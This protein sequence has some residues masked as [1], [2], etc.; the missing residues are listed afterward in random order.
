MK[1]SILLLTAVTAVVLFATP[2]FAQSTYSW[3]ISCTKSGVSGGVTWFWM[4]NGFVINGNPALG[5]GSVGCPVDQ[6]GTGIPIPQTVV[7]QTDPTT[8]L[9]VNGIQVNLS[10]SNG[11]GFCFANS[12]ILK[13]FSPSDPKFTITD[14]ISGPAH[15]D[16]FG[17]K[18][19][20]AQGSLK[21][22]IQNN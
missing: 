2:G 21:F 7:S 16:L 13:S 12:T 10:V 19:T 15:Y 20:C 6:V 8:A 3:A 17:Q 4:N 18:V 14:T 5:G 11:I 1:R 22:N 9:E